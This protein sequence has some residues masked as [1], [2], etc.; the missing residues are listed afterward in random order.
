MWFWNF[1]SHAKWSDIDGGDKEQSSEDNI[2]ICKR[3]SKG[4]MDKITKPGVS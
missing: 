4:K 1:F 2:G 3:G